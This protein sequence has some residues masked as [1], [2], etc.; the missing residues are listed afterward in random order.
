MIGSQEGHDPVG[1]AVIGVV[2]YD[3]LG[4]GQIH[5]TVTGKG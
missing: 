3:G 5:D 1:F 4:S 2:E